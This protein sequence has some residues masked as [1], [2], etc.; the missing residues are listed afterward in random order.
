MLKWTLFYAKTVL[1]NI[2]LLPLKPWNTRW[3]TMLSP[4]KGKVLPWMCCVGTNGSG[5]CTS[6]RYATL[7]SIQWSKQGPG[8]SAPERTTAPTGRDR[9]GPRVGLGGL[10][11]KENNLPPPGI[12]PRTLPP[13]N[14]LISTRKTALFGKTYDPITRHCEGN[15][16]LKLFRCIMGHLPF[17]HESITIE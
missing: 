10:W 14:K 2:E 12:K 3:K 16:I 13:S 11:Q 7:D 17:L 6:Y 5:G 9:I 1:T 8:R 4:S 15:R